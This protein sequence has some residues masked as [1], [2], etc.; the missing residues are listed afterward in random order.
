[1]SAKWVDYL[2]TE[3]DGRKGVVEKRVPFGVEFSVLLD[4]KGIRLSYDWGICGTYVGITGNKGNMKLEWLDTGYRQITR[5]LTRW[6][7]E[8]EYNKENAEAKRVLE[9]RNALIR[10]LES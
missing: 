7:N 3:I 2:V 10:E 5:A 4:D 6:Y 1:M 9:S 8:V